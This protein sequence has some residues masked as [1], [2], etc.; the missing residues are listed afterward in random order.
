MPANASITWA[1][2]V[3]QSNSVATF[4][5]LS[6][7]VAPYVQLDSTLAGRCAP[8]CRSRG[9]TLCCQ[10]G[11]FLRLLLEGHG[12]PDRPGVGLHCG[13]SRTHKSIL[14]GSI[15]QGGHLLCFGGANRGVWASCCPK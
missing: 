1:N 6:N 3:N 15:V 9:A 7:V 4:Y 13:S 8:C 10:D 14:S 12:L 2:F 11:L 5:V